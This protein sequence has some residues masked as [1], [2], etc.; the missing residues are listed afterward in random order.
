MDLECAKGFQRIAN[1]EHYQEK[2]D[3]ERRKAENENQTGLPHNPSIDV[4]PLT[5]KDECSDLNQT[6]SDLNQEVV[7]IHG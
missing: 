5:S 6:T 2:A 4:L 3:I 1:L 7:I